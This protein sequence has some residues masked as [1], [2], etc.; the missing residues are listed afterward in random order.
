M[1]PKEE[2]ISAIQL[3]GK[4]SK[5][6][7]NLALS[8]EDGRN[9][10][11]LGVLLLTHNSFQ[12]SEIY[13]EYPNFTLRRDILSYDEGLSFATKILSGANLELPN[14]GVIG[15]L[16][17]Q[18]STTY[19]QFVPSRQDFWK[20]FSL[21]WPARLVQ[22]RCDSNDI[23]PVRNDALTGKD[24]PL[25]PDPARGIPVF[26]DM[27]AQPDVFWNNFGYFLVIIPDYRAHFGQLKIIYTK[28][29]LEIRTL[30]V[31][32]EK[33]A[34]KIFAR[35]G[36]KIAQSPDLQCEQQIVDYELGFEPDYILA[37]LIMKDTG[38]HL[39]TREWGV[40]WRH[41]GEIT[42][43]RPGQQIR[44]LINRGENLNVELKL[45]L[46]DK[47]D[48]FLESVVSFANTAGGVIILGVNNH[49]EIVGFHGTDD[50]IVN[51]I[52][53]GCDPMIETKITHYELDGK[54]V[55]VV[56]IGVGDNPPYLAK[57]RGIIYVRRGGNDFPASRSD[58]DEIM[59]RVKKSDIFNPAAYH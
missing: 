48:E 12:R 6:E 5:F 59:S 32:R 52:R 28:T 57:S 46:D 25:Y 50:D 7:L 10:I 33:L 58:Y 18:Q 38:E 56:D 37:H 16:A 8:K 43:E 54:Q 39:D 30:E 22:L 15:P 45:S 21:D 29:S 53:N 14:V 26:L 1:S 13:Y 35:G 34:V 27:N 23:P 31:S 44:E 42:I 3:Q 20:L 36:S 55:F 24:V 40:S 17:I 49:R 9:K 11:A 2:I 41:Q 19:I 51:K 47:S 4:E